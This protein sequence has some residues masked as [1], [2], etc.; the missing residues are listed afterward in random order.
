MSS[1][2]KSKYLFLAIILAFILPGCGPAAD[3]Y[4]QIVTI[5]TDKG[6]MKMILF[7]DTPLHKKSFLELASGGAYDSTSFHRVIKGFMIQGGDIS[8]NEDFEKESRR[9]IPAEIRSHYMHTKGMVGAAR[10]PI[11][12]N[13]QKHSSTQ[14]YIIQGKQ[15][16]EEEIRTDIAK[17][18]GALSK[19]LYDGE[20]EELVNKFKELQDSGKTDELQKQVLALRPE[21]EEALGMSFENT[22]ITNEQVKAYTSIGGAPHLDNDYTIFGKV[23]EGLEVIDLIAVEPVDS[24]NNPIQPIYMKVAVEDVLKSDITAKY[25]VIYPEAEKN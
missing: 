15:F 12:Q 8:T 18:N 5:S 21:M 14:F 23:V 2:Q 1:L 3:E 9:L 25:G 6:E 24:L 7:N 11:N 19:Y 20:H 10:Q 4:D 13:P 17:L 22:E 16:A